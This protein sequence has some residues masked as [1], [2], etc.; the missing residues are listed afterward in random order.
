MRCRSLNGLYRKAQCDETDS[1]VS[2]QQHSRSQSRRLFRADEKE[3][4]Q[5][6]G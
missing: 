5:R 3:N 6:R 1:N 2:E 4:A